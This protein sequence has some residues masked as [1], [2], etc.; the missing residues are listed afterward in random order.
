MLGRV[1]EI[2]SAA[3]DGLSRL[4]KRMLFDKNHKRCTCV[5]VREAVR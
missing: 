3:L 2:A 5:A 1:L 4:A